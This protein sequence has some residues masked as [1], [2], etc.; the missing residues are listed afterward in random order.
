MTDEKK[1]EL[2]RNT[3]ILSLVTQILQ[4]KNNIDCCDI[5]NDIITIEGVAKSLRKAF[6]FKENK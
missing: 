4:L 1:R 3:K 5:E 6:G 2:V